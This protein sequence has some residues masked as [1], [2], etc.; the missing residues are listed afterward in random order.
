M[1]I[2]PVEMDGGFGCIEVFILDFSDFSTV[3]G[4]GQYG[5]EALQIQQRGPVA[6]LLVR[7]KA[8]F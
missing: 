8:D 7:G 4:I 1:N 3:H 2:K 6:D 5:A